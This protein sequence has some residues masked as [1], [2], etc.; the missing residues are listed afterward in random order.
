MHQSVLLHVF[1]VCHKLFFPWGLCS[2][3]AEQG[4]WFMKF[5]VKNFH[6]L[7]AVCARVLLWW[8]YYSPLC[9]RQGHIY[10]ILPHKTAKKNFEIKSLIDSLTGRNKFLMDNCFHIVLTMDFTWHTFLW[11]GKV[12]W[13]HWL[14][15]C[16]VYGLQP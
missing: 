14:C 10:L 12:K 16:F 8:N 1:H 3:I 11:H 4:E 7:K 5:W 2:W 9:H 6:T 15:C 13:F